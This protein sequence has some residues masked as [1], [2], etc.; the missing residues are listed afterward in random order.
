MKS[1]CAEKHTHT[2]QMTKYKLIKN[3]SLPLNILIHIVIVYLFYFN[4]ID[5]DVYT[6]CVAHPEPY[7]LELYDHTRVFLQKHVQGLL[8]QIQLEPEAE[9]SRL[10]RRYH[11]M[12]IQYSQG[13]DFLNK[14]YS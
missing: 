5:R 12:W 4:P 2:Q 14:L 9:Q 10:L 11:E 3:T 8:L 6:L 13:V 1:V 7:T